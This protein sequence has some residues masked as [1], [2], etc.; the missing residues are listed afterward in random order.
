MSKVTYTLADSEHMTTFN[1]G[2]VNYLWVKQ[3]TD[4]N[5]VVDAGQTEHGGLLNSR[6]MVLVRI[7]PGSSFSPG[8]GVNTKFI[9]EVKPP[10]GA[11]LPVSR[12][13]P[14]GMT[15]NKWYDVY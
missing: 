1:N 10:I 15:A 14:A 3:N 2:T 7:V 5:G 9:V 6:E 4:S 11:A 12:T 13:V 8:I